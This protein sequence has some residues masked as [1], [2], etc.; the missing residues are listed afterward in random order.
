MGI[1]KY[2]LIYGQLGSSAQIQKRQDA[3]QVQ[4]TALVQVL[5]EQKLRFE[6]FPGKTA[7]GVDGFT[8][9]AKVYER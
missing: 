1:V 9:K 7:D 6:V 3:D 8:S 2:E 5:P 4:A